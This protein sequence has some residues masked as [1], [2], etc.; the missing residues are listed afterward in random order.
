[1][2]KTMTYCLIVSVIF[3]VIQSRS[4]AQDC[5]FN[6]ITYQPPNSALCYQQQSV[7]STYTTS[8]RHRLRRNRQV[9]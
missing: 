1:M 4:M 5:Y 8:V 3:C 2:I 9:Q 7:R 6:S